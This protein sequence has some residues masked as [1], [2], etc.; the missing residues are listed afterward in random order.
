MPQHT[1]GKGLYFVTGA[2]IKG[3]CSSIGVRWIMRPF[4]LSAG[5]DNQARVWKL[6]VSGRTLSIAVQQTS[7]AELNQS[8]IVYGLISGTRYIS[9]GINTT[10]FVL[11]PYKC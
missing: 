2:S 9:V 3:G 1:S 7:G 4:Q 10:M 5:S 11:R 6:S 8:V